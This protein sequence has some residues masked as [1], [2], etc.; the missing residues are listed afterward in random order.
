MIRG[1]ALSFL[2]YGFNWLL[3][4]L[5]AQLAVS[6][7]SWAPDSKEITKKEAISAELCITSYDLL[8]ALWPAQI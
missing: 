2:A 3:Q 7:F 1:L 8:S 6:Q 5:I 4:Y